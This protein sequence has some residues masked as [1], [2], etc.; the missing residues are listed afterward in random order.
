MRSMAFRSRYRQGEKQFFQR[1]LA[2]GGMFG[3]APLLSILRRRT[4]LSPCRRSGSRLRDLVEQGV[5]GG[6]IRH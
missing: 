1:R 6:A 5:G 4:S 2:F 3:A